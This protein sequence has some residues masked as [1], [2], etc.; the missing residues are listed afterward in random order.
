[1]QPIS[2]VRAWEGSGSLRSV[3]VVIWDGERCH[4]ALADREA[5]VNVETKWVPTNSADNGGP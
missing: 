4:A 1:M 3:N 5:D 2:K